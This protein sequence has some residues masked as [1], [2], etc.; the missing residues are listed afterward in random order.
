M[1]FVLALGV[2]WF[3]NQRWPL[4]ISS[5]LTEPTPT[6]VFTILGAIGFA[7]TFASMLSFAR[8]NTSVLPHRPASK[9]VNRGLYRYSRNPMYVGLIIVYICGTLLL[10][11]FWLAFLLV[12][13]LLG[14]RYFIIAK[15]ETYLEQEFGDEYLQYKQQVRRWL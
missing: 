5:S 10:N 12:P 8:A 9:M 6:V 7:L 14:L 11:T 3:L 13:V 2:G 4:P 15:E 1:I